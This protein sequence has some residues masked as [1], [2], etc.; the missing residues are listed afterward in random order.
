MLDYS[1]INNTSVLPQLSCDEYTIENEQAWA[2]LS[3]MQRN[4]YVWAVDIYQGER[5]IGEWNYAYES[6]FYAN[7]VIEGLKKMEISGDDQN[8]YNYIL[9]QAYFTRAFSFYDLAK[10][11]APPFDADITEEVLGIPLKLTPNVDQNVGRASLGETYRQILEDLETSQRFLPDRITAQRN[12]ASKPAAYALA[13][14]IYLSMRKYDLSERYADSCLALYNTLID[15]NQL[16]LTTDAPFTIDNEESIFFAR[17]GLG[18]SVTQYTSTVAMSINR[19][20]YALYEPDDLRKQV[21]FF[22]N[23]RD[24]TIKTKRGYSGTLRFPY[25]GLAIDEIMLIKAEC[26]VRRGD[27]ETSLSVIN[28]LL[29]HR[30]RKDTFT[31]IAT[32]SS[33][34]LLGLV[35]NERRKELIWRAGLRWDDIRRLNLEGAGIVLSRQIGTKEYKLEPKSSRFT[36]PIPDDEI[37]LSGIQQNLRQ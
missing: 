8:E 22:I 5:G 27:I 14:R 30:Y 37:A 21:F 3:P 23:A 20:L 7:N 34:E 19:E 36:F 12:R 31:P 1:R 29:L 16:S 26:A 9:G 25:A 13:A 17:Y 32:S 24:S 2:A 15:Y 33:E 18:H 35:L 11:F 28:R 4:A 10:N 6:V